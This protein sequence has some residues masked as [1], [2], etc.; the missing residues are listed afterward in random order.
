VGWVDGIVCGAVHLNCHLTPCTLQ[1]NLDVGAAKD[2]LVLQLI[3]K[4][5]QSHSMSPHSTPQH[6]ATVSPRHA[7]PDAE[8]TA[9][10]LTGW[11]NRW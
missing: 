8:G 4:Q 5:L 7:M 3:I 10:S 1:G 11:T 2:G 9:A 6:S